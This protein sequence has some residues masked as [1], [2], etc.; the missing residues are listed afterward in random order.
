MLSYEKRQ[1]LDKAND[2]VA[3]KQQLGTELGKVFNC[4]KGNWK[5]SRDG[6]AVSDITLKDADGVSTLKIPSGALVM[7][8]LV[9]AKSAVTS[10][11]SL[12]LDVNVQSANDGL[13]G[14]AVASL[15]ANAKIQ[16]I[17]D[18]ATVADYLVLTA[19]RTPTISF[20][21][22]AATAG[23]LDVYFFYVF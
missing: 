17:P 18:F 13:A 5:F 12:T 16:G 21:V 4:V 14:T 6:G 9:F 1:A 22:A 8:V 20:N 11:G 10:G 23:E 19:E 15:T 2:W 3:A 7:G